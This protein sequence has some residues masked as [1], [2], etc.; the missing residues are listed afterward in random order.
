MKVSTQAH[1]GTL[2]KT[3]I[4]IYEWVIGLNMEET[5]TITTSEL[6]QL[7]D[8]AIRNDEHNTFLYQEIH[9]IRHNYDKEVR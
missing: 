2:K 6:Q 7:L 5:I 3:D 1:L 4:H 8:W 9:Y